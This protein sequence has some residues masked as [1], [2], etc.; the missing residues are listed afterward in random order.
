M[1]SKEGVHMGQ[2]DGAK[3]PLRTPRSSFLTDSTALHHFCVRIIAATF[4]AAAAAAST[5][6]GLYKF[7]QERQGLRNALWTQLATHSM[8]IFDQ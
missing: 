7:E 3:H 1:V 6:E 8:L 5:A 2:H 4:A